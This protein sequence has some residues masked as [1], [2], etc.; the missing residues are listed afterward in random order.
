MEYTFVNP[1]NILG[2][3][4][5]DNTVIKYDGSVS[6]SPLPPPIPPTDYLLREGEYGYYY[7]NTFN[8]SEHL[9]TEQQK[10]NAYYLYSALSDKGWTLN[11][12][13]GILGNMEVES[14]INPGRWQS[15]RIGGDPERAWLWIS[16]MDTLY[17]IH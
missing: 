13:C 7:G 5:V 2:V 17:K 4:N 1:A 10:I 6:P 8:S 14:S 16:T 11:S 15:D 12:I 9:T 3:P